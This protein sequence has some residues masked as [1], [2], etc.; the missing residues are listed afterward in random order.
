[1]GAISGIC[2]INEAQSRGCCIVLSDFFFNIQSF[3]DFLCLGEFS[4]LFHS[5]F[6]FSRSLGGFFIPIGVI[7][8][9]CFWLAI[10][11]LAGLR[12]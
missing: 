9:H 10:V 1:V 3:L 5:D 7:S 11:I 12:S 6:A 8:F 2:L 4:T